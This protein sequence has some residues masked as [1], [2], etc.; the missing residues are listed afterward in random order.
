MDF[1]V[2]KRKNREK[3]YSFWDCIKFQRVVNQG[4][5]L[6]LDSVFVVM[7][8]GALIHFCLLN[9][10]SFMMLTS[11]FYIVLSVQIERSIARSRENIFRI[12]PIP[13]QK[14][15]QLRWGRT[16]G[17]M[18]RY[19]LICIVVENV[20]QQVLYGTSMIGSLCSGAY[21]WFLEEFCLETVYGVLYMLF[22]TMCL[23]PVTC[24]KKKQAIRYGVL[25]LVGYGLMTLVLMH[26]CK[27]M[28]HN[29]CVIRIDFL[30]L[31]YDMYELGFIPVR[32]ALWILCSSIWAV[33]SY[34]ICY[35][36]EK[37]ICANDAAEK[38][39][40]E[41]IQKKIPKAALLGSA[42]LSFRPGTSF[43][44]I[45]ISVSMMIPVVAG[46]H[47][48]W[49]GILMVMVI[50]E[51]V[52]VSFIAVYFKNRKNILRCLPMSTDALI[53]MALKYVSMIMGIFG[54][55]VVIGGIV[56]S[57]LVLRE[58]LF[59]ELLPVVADSV[60]KIICIVCWFF[61]TCWLAVPYV[62]AHDKKGHTGVFTSFFLG[63]VI[64]TILMGLPFWSIGGSSLLVRLAACMVLPLAFVLRGWWSY[65]EENHLAGLPALAKLLIGIGVGTLVVYVCMWMLQDGGAFDTIIFAEDAA[66]SVD[67]LT[68]VS[69]GGM[70]IGVM[71]VIGIVCVAAA[72]MFSIREMRWLI[73][74]DRKKGQH[75]F[76]KLY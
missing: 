61:C 51:I 50:C 18:V 62:F 74:P 68:L 32:Y 69:T 42:S 49:L 46:S 52:I 8:V 57:A 72:G 47:E 48:F 26:V 3:G 63:V 27:D 41:K 36:Q 43:L 34:I 76:S 2:R 4:D 37:K 58:D 9:G 31:E 21:R 15:V 70:R 24:L 13:E 19:L 5:S 28:D 35:L 73:A 16:I 64:V 22:F 55:A 10:G 66:L 20:M 6:K 45:L 67:L 75:D 17:G 12:V 7:L 1:A 60:P 30:N 29:Y 53:K 59:T 14:Q 65:L 11:F 56:G 54:G 23:M 40:A 33:A 38:I 44:V 71:A 25:T 39:K